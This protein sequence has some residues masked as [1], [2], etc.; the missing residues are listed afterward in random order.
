[1]MPTLAI[2]PVVI[3]RVREISALHA[4]LER[5]LAMVGV[6]DAGVDA[7]ILASSMASLRR[8]V[9]DLATAIFVESVRAYVGST[10]AAVVVVEVTPTLADLANVATPRP[11]RTYA[12]KGYNTALVKATYQ[13][14]TTRPCAIA[15]ATG[16]LVQN[17]E[18][19][20]KKLRTQG[21]IV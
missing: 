17:V 18:Y 20:L 7:T 12:G 1:M 21:E 13:G 15:R 8:R 6:P 9:D 14:G 16:L 3:E 11:R 4:M 19:H 2:T 10:P 5:C